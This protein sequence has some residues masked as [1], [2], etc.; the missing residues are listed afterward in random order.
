MVV[1]VTGNAYIMVAILTI[2]NY[3]AASIACL[4]FGV[5]GKINLASSTFKIRFFIYIKSKMSFFFS[6]TIG[7]V[8]QTVLRVRTKPFIRFT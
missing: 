4:G 8:I 5:P 2:L 3:S 1:R 6:S 7:Y